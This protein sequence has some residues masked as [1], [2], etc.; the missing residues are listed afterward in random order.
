MKSII[1]SIVIA[2]GI[3]YFYTL[4]KDP[5]SRFF[6]IAAYLTIVGPVMLNYTMN[7]LIQRTKKL[8]YYENK[9]KQQ[10]EKQKEK[11]EAK[12]GNVVKYP[13]KATNNP[14]YENLK[15]IFAVMLKSK[16][17][18]RKNILEFSKRI[19][20]HLGEY[21]AVYKDMKYENDIHQIY[22]KMKSDKLTTEHY[23]DLQYFL[24][25]IAEAI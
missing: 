6:Y 5:L 8:T 21:A 20:K 2:S 12:E 24:E 7:V 4:L 17:L 9:V 16:S 23:R 25:E 15:V 13:I 19:D 14:E 11:E 3:F 18:T 10:E 1:T 22:V